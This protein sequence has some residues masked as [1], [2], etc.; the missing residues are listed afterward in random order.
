MVRGRRVDGHVGEV[1]IA[2]AM[3]GLQN[4]WFV[5]VC[6]GSKIRQQHIAQESVSGTVQGFIMHAS[7]IPMAASYRG[8]ERYQFSIRAGSFTDPRRFSSEISD[9]RYL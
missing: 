4:T 8:D 5:S 2:W 6:T 9:T 3:H 1:A 7:G